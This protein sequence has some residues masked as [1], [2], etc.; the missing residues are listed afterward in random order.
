MVDKPAYSPED[1][2][3]IRSQFAALE[4]PKRQLSTRQFIIDEMMPDIERKLKSGWRYDDLVE[5]L[6][7]V[8]ISIRAN[9]LR[10][11]VARAR[12][13]S[14]KKVSR[15][16]APAHPKT[17]APT[18]PQEPA[19]ATQNPPTRRRSRRQKPDFAGFDESP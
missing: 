11:Y 10:N 9:T 17:A 7:Q 8:G 4:R 2:D 6:R 14:A 3:G 5:G 15:K 18:G 16:T 1:A 12:A 19:T 13:K